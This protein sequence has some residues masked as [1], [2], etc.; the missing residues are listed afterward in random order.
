MSRVKTMFSEYLFLPSNR[1]AIENTSIIQMVFP[2]NKGEGKNY[3]I[4]EAAVSNDLLKNID[5]KKI[6]D[7]LLQYLAELWSD[8]IS[9]KIKEG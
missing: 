7:S 8:A 4:C 9:S 5:D 6:L 2:V 3:V 1:E